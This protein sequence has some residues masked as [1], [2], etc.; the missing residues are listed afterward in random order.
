MLRYN[1]V[2]SGQEPEGVAGEAREPAALRQGGYERRHIVS[3]GR[4][5]NTYF[6]ARVVFCDD[7]SGGRGR[8]VEAPSTSP[9]P[10]RAAG[11]WS[12]FFYSTGVSYEKLLFYEAVLQQLHDDGLEDAATSLKQQLNVE[13]NGLLR[14]DHLFDLFRKT[15]YLSSRTVAGASGDDPESAQHERDVRM[16]Q[17]L[18]EVNADHIPLDPLYKLAGFATFCDF[19]T[20]RVGHR[21]RIANSH[22]AVPMHRGVE[23]RKPPSNRRRRRRAPRHPDR[24]CRPRHPAEV[25]ASVLTVTPAPESP[26]GRRPPGSKGTRSRSRRSTFTP[27]ATSSHQEVR[28]AT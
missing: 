3:H 15:A 27:D 9:E 25:R 24:R 28:G 19:P 7:A 12:P 16:H 20:Y 17:I 2:A 23:R 5:S 14:K 18:N 26:T 6:G 10:T 8:E 21:A 11:C 1:K 4:P 22:A 13:P